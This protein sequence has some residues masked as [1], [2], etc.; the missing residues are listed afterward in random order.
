[1]KKLVSLVVIAVLA[2]SVYAQDTLMLRNRRKVEGTLTGASATYVFIT[3]NDG[4]NLEI[5]KEIIKSA[6]KGKNNITSSLMIA[7]SG[8]VKHTPEPNIEKTNPVAYSVQRD[9][10]AVALDRLN[11]TLT[12]IAVPLWASVIA[13]VVIAL[14]M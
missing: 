1:M 7:D 9:P 11:D 12:L 8:N 3:D 13:G 6:Y 14:T 2:I 5:P 10:Q 4:V